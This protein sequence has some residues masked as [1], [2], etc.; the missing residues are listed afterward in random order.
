MDRFFVYAFVFQ[1]F[2]RF[3]AVK[4]GIKLEIHVVQYSDRLPEVGI[5]AR[6]FG[7]ITQNPAHGERVTDM[8]RLLIVFLYDFFCFFYG[9]FV[10]PD[11]NSTV[12]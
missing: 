3:H 7:K 9:H 12:F 1:N 5:F 11:M 4:I 6:R 10:P 8:E 2:H